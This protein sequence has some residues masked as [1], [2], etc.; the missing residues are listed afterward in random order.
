[1]PPMSAPGIVRNG[2]HFI[3]VVALINWL[4][5]TAARSTPVASQTASA[6]ANEIEKWATR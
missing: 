5:L 6:I 3:S 1:M 2:V 4:H